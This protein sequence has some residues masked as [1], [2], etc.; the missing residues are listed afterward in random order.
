MIHGGRLL[1]VAPKAHLPNYREFYE[2]RWFAAGD[3]RSTATDITVGEHVAPFGT[4][5]LF[6]AEDLPDLTFHVEICED[7]WVPVPPSAIAALAGAHV[8]LNLSRQPDHHRPRRG[9]ADAGQ[10]APA[11]AAR[12]RTSTPPP[13]RAS[14]RPT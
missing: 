12:R 6:R 5:L 4:D 11:P 1:G 2:R 8:L 3:R 14:R 10:A 9:P 7:M 13:A